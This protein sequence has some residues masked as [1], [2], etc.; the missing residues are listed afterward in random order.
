MNLLCGL[1]CQR[2]RLDGEAGIG[3]KYYWRTGAC[4]VTFL[5]DPNDFLVCVTEI[6][7]RAEIDA[8]VEGLAGISDQKDTKSQS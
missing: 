7:S 1:Q 5:I 6:N 4:L 2:G 8:L 3:T